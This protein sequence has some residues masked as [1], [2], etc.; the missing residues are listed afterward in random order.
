M[1][2]ADPEMNFVQTLTSRAASAYQ[3]SKTLA[4]CVNSEKFNTVRTVTTETITEGDSQLVFV[5]TV[6]DLGNS[7]PFE[8]A[9]YSNGVLLDQKKLCRPT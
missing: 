6:A 9:L 4:L 8:T 1:L 5:R 3:I 2:Y 7:F